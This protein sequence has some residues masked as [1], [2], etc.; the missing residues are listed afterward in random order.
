MTRKKGPP[1]GLGPGPSS[2][3]PRSLNAATLPGYMDPAGAHGEVW[4]A[5]MKPEVEG[6]KL[7]SNP[8]TLAKTVQA[9]VGTIAEAYRNRDDHLVIKV[10]GM[11]K[12][13]KLLRLKQLIGSDV[14]I[15]VEEH[16][17]LNQSKV[18]VTCRS[19]QDLS[20]DQLKNEQSLKEQG[21]IDVRRF[22]KNGQPTNTMIV[23]VRGTVPPEAI[24]FGFERCNAKPFVQAPMQC[25]RCYEYGHTKHRCRVEKEVCR[26]C[27]KTHDDEKDSDGKTV[28]SRPT[29]CMHCKGEH[30]PA[31]RICEKYREEEEILKVRN[32][33]GKSP[34]DARLYVEEQKQQQARSYARIAAGNGKSVQ[35]RIAAAQASSD[36]ITALRKELEEAKKGKAEA[37]AIRKELAESRK[38]LKAALR[39]IRTLK[40]EIEAAKE[41]GESSDDMDTADDQSEDGKG[42][43]ANDKTE[44]E[45][46]QE[47]KDEVPK[48]KSGQIKR[49]I[50]E[51]DSPTEG[52][53]EENNN[54]FKIKINKNNQPDPKKAKGPKPEGKQPRSRSNS[55]RRSKQ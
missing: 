30:S 54:I 33:L 27:S 31:A 2:M 11:A 49:T 6:E 12:F 50:S 53:E 4:T 55:N 3:S 40:K 44:E 5:V 8:F 9:S 42:T 36:D 35:D 25:Y 23:T 46:N 17:F 32:T 43:E 24:Y 47:T 45:L 10:R 51:T 41:D 1:P 38:A 48:E 22:K 14:K 39:E 37:E 28:C 15:V 21:V 29:W 13:T 26:N 34:R 7:P 20:E 19:V 16:P 52:T 18:V